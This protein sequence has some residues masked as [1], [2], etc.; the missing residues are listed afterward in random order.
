MMQHLP[1]LPILIP[2]FAASIALFFE[3]RRFGMVPQRIV[4]WVS[5]ASMLAVCG[6]LVASAA[7]GDVSVYLLGD[8]PARLGIVLMVDR[9]SALM[10]LVGLLLAAACLLH[11]CAGWDRR[12]PHFHA[13]FQFQLMGLNGA[14]LTGDVF[15]LFV[16]FEVLLISSYGLMLSGGRGERMRAG[17]HYV[18]FNIAAS[19]LFLIALGLLYGMLGSLNMAELSARV[20]QLPP[21]DVALVQAA[22]GLLF[23]VFCAKA[24][25]LPMYFWL[26]ETYTHAPAAVAGLFA[27]MTKVGLYA[28]LRLGTLTFGASGPL[29]GFAWPALLALGAVTLVL[30]SLGVL[31][32]V[33]LRALAAYLVLG[34]AAT[35]FVA[36][37]LSTVG[38]V[39]A[40]LYYL[41]HSSFAGAALFLLADLIRRRRGRASD[42]KDLI[43]ALPDKTVPGLLFLVAAVSLAGLPPLSGF[44]G[45]LLLLE[46]VPAGP[47]TPWIWSLVLGTS[48]L[49]LVGL[50]RAGTRL[51]WRV[52]P[53]PD[54]GTHKLEAYTPEQDLA[55]A[56]SRPLETAAILVLLGYG[57]ALVLAAAPVLDYTRA[58]AEQIRAPGDYVDHVRAAAPLLREP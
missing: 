42:R 43:A 9:L 20:A 10:L 37:S 40:G 38:T 1:A 24:A 11:A 19:T 35:L 27:I 17:L 54:A 5:I 28:V 51:F 44:I 47:R 46:A 30:A 45:K 4:A 21:G 13:F 48:F 6:V 29:D 23:V 32:A 2:L 16:F 3:H 57:V 56:P 39:G 7:S 34:S 14:F 55:A 50:A 26:P 33:R 22:A 52:E 58:T 12:A 25:L 15:N 41:V 36:F 18:A 49:M 31:A 8:W 53:W